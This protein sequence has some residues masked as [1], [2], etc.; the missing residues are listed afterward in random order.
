MARELTVTEE[1]MRQ[2]ALEALGLVED[3]DT[4]TRSVKEWAGFLGISEWMA[5]TKI[6]KAV[7]AGT[8]ERRP[9]RQ[10]RS[11]GRLVTVPGY[12]L[13]KQDD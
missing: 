3:D 1:E 9:K 8:M 13:V 5:R 7:E 11:D 10:R 4:D 2:A 12:R 6:R